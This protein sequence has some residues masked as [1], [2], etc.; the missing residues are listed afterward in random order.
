MISS[1]SRGFTLAVSLSFIAAGALAQDYFEF[2]GE[3]GGEVRAFPE[4]PQFDG[5]LSGFQPSAFA[6]LTWEWEDEARENQLTGVVFGRLDGRDSER[7]HADVREAYYRRIGEDWEALI[8][9]NRVFWGVTESRHLVN[10]I[11][12]IDAVENIDEEDYLGQPMLNL[13]TQ[14]DYGRFDLFVMPGFRERTFAGTDGRLR[15]GL[16]VDEDASTFESGLGGGHP[17]VALRYNHFLGNWDVGAHV[18]Y[19]HGREPTLTPNEAGTQLEPSY[20]LITQGGV[21]LQYTT[22]AWLWKF[23]GLVREGQGDTFGAMVGGFEYTEFQVFDTDADLGLLAEYL[24]DGRDDDAP[25]TTF[26]NDLFFGARVTLNDIEDTALLAGAVVDL[27]YGSVSGRLEAERRFGDS[28]KGE[29]EVQIFGHVAEDDPGRAFEN[30]SFA[31]LRLTR[32][33]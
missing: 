7:T 8:G 6:E 25:L 2:S 26:Q 20:D 22:D 33:F 27:E 15:G 30:D 14:R 32:F 28:W 9:L 5:Q 19:G 17:D 11:N 18:F 13:A 29:I 1:L 12:Q 24:Y 23:E 31:L 3:V 16:T 4:S 10:V 21:D